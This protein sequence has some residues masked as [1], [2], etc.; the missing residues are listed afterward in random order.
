MA[1]EM[2]HSGIEW[3]G[4]IPKGWDILPF[5]QM[6]ELGKGL[7]ITKADLVE[8]GVP[9]ISYG[10]IHSK[11]NSG[12]TIKDELIRFV[13][14]TFLEGNSS[15]LV[16][17][18]DVIFA[19]TSEDLDGCGNCI[20]IDRDSVM[21]AGY[22]TIIA[23]Y[24]SFS[25]NNYLSYLFKTDCWRSQIRSSVNGVKLFSVPQRLLGSTT[26]IVPPLSEQQ[27]I[28]NYLD[29][30]CGEVDEMIALQ[31]QM[32]EELKAYKQSVI[33]EAVTKGLNPNV[34][35]KDSGID[36]IGEVP[37]EW[38]VE[39][40]KYLIS[41]IE[42]GVSVNAGNVPASK[43]EIGVL[44]TSCVSKYIF[45]AN[46]NKTVYSNE[47]GRVAC[48]VRAN[49][50]IVSRMNTPELV[51]A[52]GYV[53]EDY[54]NI[55]LPDRL[56]QVH[57]HDVCVKYIWFVLRSS[58]IRNYYSSLSVGSSSSMQNISQDQFANATIVLPPLS[59]QQSIASY[60][61][62]KCAQIDALIAIKQQ[63]IDELKEY[64]KSVIFEYVTG[65]KEVV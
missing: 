64:K 34:P 49:T 12:T 6:Y 58:H 17:K 38:S 20:Y 27:K 15:S 10:Q 14:N 50:I 5:K 41:K 13:P 21:F 47:I 52:C 3:I 40:L 63:K 60:L 25:P 19:D 30:V 31:E 35:M 61:D 59:E 65:K 32:I 39:K 8:E 42:S 55:Y 57:F 16:K 18:G 7:S 11:S 22:H 45:D 26:I 2:R 46:E 51:G 44:K 28:A 54:D 24:L 33:T 48:P 62:T 1:R 9:V 29:K 36:W 23:K 37:E 43:N 53:N 4:E 56:W